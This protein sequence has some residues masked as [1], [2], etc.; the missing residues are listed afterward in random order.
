MLTLITGATGGLGRS[1][2]KECAEKGYDLILSATKQERLEELKHEILK[3]YPNIKIWTKECLLNSKDSREEL[4][5]FLKKEGLQP[6]M[7]INNAGYILEGSIMGTKKEEIESC[8]DV[9]ILGTTELTYWFVENRN[10]QEKGYILFVSSMAGYYPMPQMSTYAST[11]AYL[12]HTSISLRWELRKNNVNVSV[13]CPGSMATND[14]MKRS[15][16]S[17]GFGGKLSL[18]STEKIAKV[19]IK[20]LLKNKAIWVP[21]FFNKVMILCSKIFPKTLIARFVGRRWTNCEKKRGEYR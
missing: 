16:K 1:Y 8:I 13:V 4:Y 3:T 10:K 14:A 21:G 6:N 17:Q 15:I 20:K 2:V 7:L 19:S 5:S 18:Q 9:N 12:T 11:K